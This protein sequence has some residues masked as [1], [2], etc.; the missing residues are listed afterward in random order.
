[1]SSGEK[2]DIQ[3]VSSDGRVHGY[4]GVLSFAVQS[5]DSEWRWMLPNSM[6]RI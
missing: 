6:M 5:L 3:A 4:H 2:P 1:M